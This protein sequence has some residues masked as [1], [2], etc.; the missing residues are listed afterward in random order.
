M[1]NR[2]KSVLVLVCATFMLNAFS[3]KDFIR[4]DANLKITY[5]N[6]DLLVF[7][8]VNFDGKV[9]VVFSDIGDYCKV[10][11]IMADNNTAFSV[12]CKANIVDGKSASI[13]LPNS[14]IK[15]LI[16]LTNVCTIVGGKPRKIFLK[17]NTLAYV[18]LERSLIGKVFAQVHTKKRSES[19]HLNLTA[20]AEN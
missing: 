20:I 15:K 9:K 19:Y 17:E 13:E 14:S 16:K 8:Q 4:K 18:A 12:P 6:A 3:F 1:L 11:G 10:S 2:V 7:D 5:S